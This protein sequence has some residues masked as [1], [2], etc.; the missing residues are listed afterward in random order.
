MVQLQN[1][2]LVTKWCRFQSEHFGCDRLRERSEPV[3]EPPGPYPRCRGLPV[4][5]GREA[6]GPCAHRQEAGQAGISYIFLKGLSHEIDIKKTDKFTELGLSNGRGWFFKCFRGSNDFK[7]QRDPYLGQDL[8]SSD[9]VPLS[10]DPAKKGISKVQ[11][12]ELFDKVFL[13]QKNC[14]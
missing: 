3:C 6:A 2:S 13:T 1:K 12:I 8:P 4:G 10:T 5:T 9:P 14:Y 7:M 11:K